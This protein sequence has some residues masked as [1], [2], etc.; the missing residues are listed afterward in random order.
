MVFPVEFVYIMVQGKLQ[1]ST[2]VSHN[3]AP[4]NTISSYIFLLLTTGHIST[5]CGADVV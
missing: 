1:I 2:R 3:N 5:S 4:N